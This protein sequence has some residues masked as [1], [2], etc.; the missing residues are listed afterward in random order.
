MNRGTPRL[1]AAAAA[2]L[3]LL[4]V[5]AQAQFQ[6]GNI[7]GKVVAKD[8]AMLPGV[9]VTLTGVAA[10][11]TAITDSEGNFRFIGLSPGTYSIRAE[12]SEFGTATRNGVSVGVGGNADVTIT[13]NPSVN[14]AIT[15]TAEAPLLDV[16]KTGT[17]ANIGLVEMEKVPTARDPW[18]ILQSTPGV[19]V[20]RINIGG[21]QSGQQSI[22]IS[23]GAPRND[24]TWN[25]DGVNIT[26]M[27][28]TGS[29]PT[30]YDFDTFEEMNVTTGGSDPRIQTAGVQLN[31]VT[32]R[33]TND[34]KGSG[35]YLYVPG[36]TSA[37]ASVP[38]E[39]SSY[40][41]ET[42]RVNYVR[43]Y[44][45]EIGGPIWRD[46]IWL[47]GARGDQ[48]IS[49]WQ[50]AANPR[51]SF[52]I[53]DDTVLRNK[54][55]KLN[56]QPFTANSFVA[57]YTFGDK[58]RNARDLSPTRPPASAWTQTGPTKVYKLEDT[59][60]FNSSFYL[61]GMWSKVDGGFGLFGN[62]GVGPDAPSF[63]VN[64]QGVFN[65]NFYTYQTVR[66]QKQ[67][68]LDGSAFVD[69]GVSHELKFGYGYRD[70]PVSSASIFPGPSSGFL[71]YST[72]LG[73]VNVVSPAT[74]TAQGLPSNCS[75]MFLYRPPQANYSG[76]YHE[77]Y[78]GDTLMFGNMTI[79]GGLR[80]DQQ[81][82]QILPMSIGG[83]PILSTP[84]NIECTTALGCPGG[85]RDA[86]LPGIEY[87]GQDEAL[88]WKTV[89][90]RIGIT[91]AL[92]ADRKSLLRAAYN[93]YVS[94][95]GS[96]VSGSSPVGNSYLAFYGVDANGDNTIQRNELA[97]LRTISG[98][99]LNAPNSLTSTRRIDY[100]TNPP[101]TDELLIGFEREVFR[102]VSVGITAT[103]RRTKDLLIARYEKTQGAGDFY[104][105]NDYELVGTIAGGL[106]VQCPQGFGSTA[107][108]GC[109]GNTTATT[110]QTATPI[111]SFQTSTAQVYQL[112]NGIASPNFSVITNRPDYTQT[113]NGVE[114][115]ATKR[116]ADRWMMRFNASFNDYSDDCGDD[117]FANPTVQ[118]NGTGIVNFVASSAGAPNCTGGQVAPQS[119]GSGAFG[120]VFIN[121]KWNMNLNGAYILP[122]DINI[123]ANV[124]ARQGYPAPQRATVTG[125][126]GGNPT[127]VLDEMGDI[128]FDNVYQ[129]D[130]RIAKDF[131]FFDRLGIT[132]SADVFN[133]TNERT[134]LQR[135]TGLLTNAYTAATG[136]VTT[137]SIANGWRITELQA[138]R[139]WRFGAK[140]TY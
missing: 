63:Y 112:K 107:A 120:N 139:V 91:Y 76:E 42:N 89:S 116:M 97:K 10:P 52:F 118:L 14:E 74:C 35:R 83:N 58:F 32:K 103:H 127:V 36:S 101:T 17:G 102:D 37:K 88:Q 23:K 62:G 45:G 11:Q 15:V 79:Q 46:R 135:N 123:G 130:L 3:L 126:R 65:D 5:S 94:Q 140:I 2:V 55:L 20:D 66:P 93:R 60:V 47:W 19:L 134:V 21:T 75:V 82:S 138:P 40:L 115:T 124:M 68:R 129:L 12:L 70:T 39:A 27:G 131:R 105:A 81:E 117:S 54:N 96:A 86:V 114:L 128:R 100:D 50:A 119:A 29:S 4:A 33:G 133:A 64:N 30:Y 137:S 6:T 71:S 28:A 106:F 1:I 13:M 92:G 113:Y 132:L 73:G 110:G 49:T 99:N 18:M 44:G 111:T 95:M 109:A 72:T 38:A 53:P 84:L 48:K 31:M 24:G 136:A 77:L 108:G 34:Y 69:L 51:P 57:S 78:L 59:H 122:W 16:R 7:Y 22:Y 104:S 80:Y 41:S 56:A 121:S 87:P 85:R 8:G 25:I 43:D 98:I 125:M 9:T 90:P 61:T 26:D 67:Y